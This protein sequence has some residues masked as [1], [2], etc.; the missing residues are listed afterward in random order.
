MPTLRRTRQFS[1]CLIVLH[2]ARARDRILVCLRRLNDGNAV[3]TR[4]IGEV[5]S[6]LK[7][8]YG[9]GNRVYF[10]RRDFE[11]ILLL[12]GGDKGSQ[13]NGIEIAKTLARQYR[14]VVDGA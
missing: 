2:D 9:P 8:D 7:I 4:S 13:S 3:Q 5:F 10:P 14:E 1:D 11:I 12:Y 6:E